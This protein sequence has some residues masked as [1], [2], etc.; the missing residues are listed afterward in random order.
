MEIPEGLDSLFV[1]VLVAALAPLIV[2]LLPGPRVPEVVVLLVLGVV[3]GPHVLDIAETGPEISLIANVGLGFLFFLAGFE[4][5]LSLLRGAE[6]RAA[7]IAWTVSIVAAMAVVGVLAAVGFVHA[8]LPVS[9]A[10]T[11][12]A[13]GTLL[14]M[15]RDSGET[16]GPFGRAI[17]A[18]G[19][20]GEFLPIIAI[21]L[22]LSAKGAW[23]S[24]ALL[25][26]FGALAVLVSLASRHLKGRSVAELVRLGSETSS[27]TA[28]RIAVVLLVALLLLAG[29][30]GLD[31]VLG[32]FAAGIVLRATLPEGDEALERKLD[33]LAFGFFVPAFFVVSGMRVDLPSILDNPARMFVFLALILAVR[34]LPVLLTFRSRLPGRDPIRLGLLSATALPLIVAITE[35][36]LAT[37]EMLPENAAALVGAGLLSV[38][39]FPMLARALERRPGSDT[40]STLATEE[41]A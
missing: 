16:S 26:A 23:H 31:V 17:M 27:Q 18:N 10:L 20:A 38:L 30:L 8:F 5:D 1:V 12:T 34:G 22:F 15:L 7:G 3:V 9:I 25:A 13:L 37:G 40:P 14:P 28:V 21:S 41:A 33:G 24:L 11:T 4:L 29:E 36:G 39:I 32:A 6:G 19:A 35:V 2:G